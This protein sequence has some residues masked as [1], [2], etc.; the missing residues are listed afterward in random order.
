V[1][2]LHGF[3]EC[4]FSWRH[5]IRALADAGFRA[6]APD[7]RGYGQTSR[8]VPL[9]AYDICQ[10]AGDVVGLVNGLQERTAVI[11]GHD[12]GAWITA[13]VALLRP[14]LFTKVV[15][16]SV[17]YPPRGPIAPSQW[18]QIAYPGKVFYQAALRAP[19]TDQY[20]QADIRGTLLR[21]FYTSSAEAPV[22]DRF[23]P[24][25]APGPPRQGPAKRPSWISDEEV[26][27]FE[28]S[29]R[30]SGFT[31]GLNYY[32]NMDRNW[33]LTPFLNGARILQPT[34]FIAGAEDPVIDF[35]RGPYDELE[36]NVPGLVGKVLLPNVGH[37]TQQEA[38]EEV[39]RLL[40][41]FLRS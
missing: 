33:A 35:L 38:P 30:Q 13:C 11:A 41:E 17:P 5:Q 36:S 22:Q 21:A 23:E 26:D 20:F 34:L 8:P 31:G 2:L 40:L 14:D 29:F 3:P 15:L 25:R 37:W 10:L 9:E 39:N 16:L 7:L 32:R 1:L 24:A 28:A 4:W 6:V 19:G 18:E 27:V 12:W